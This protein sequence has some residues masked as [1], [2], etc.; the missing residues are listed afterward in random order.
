MGDF[1][2]GLAK[3]STEQGGKDYV[4]AGKITKVD[5]ALRKVTF[6]PFNPTADPWTQGCITSP[7]HATNRRDVDDCAADNV[8]QFFKKF[9]KSYKFPRNVQRVLESHKIQ[10]SDSNRDDRPGSDVSE[11][12]CSS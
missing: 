10:W 12:S 8:I 2:V 7:W 11:F 3:E 9:T 1:V 4:F 5:R 6:K